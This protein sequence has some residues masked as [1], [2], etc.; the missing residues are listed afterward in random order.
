MTVKAVA[1]YIHSGHLNFKTAPYE[2]WVRIMNGNVNVNDNFNRGIAKAQYPWRLFH[3]L[4]FRWE[5]PT[6]WKNK[7]EARLRFV[8]PVSITFDTFPD[9]ARYE[10]I[11]FVWD[12][13][14]CYFEKMCR[15][16]DKHEVK[17]AIFTS[18]Q[19]ADRIRKRFP[20]MNIMYCPE[21][22]DTSN[23]HEGKPLKDRSIDVL[24]FGRNGN[25]NGITEL[26]NYGTTELR[27]YGDTD[28]RRDGNR[29]YDNENQ[30]EKGGRGIRYVCTKVDGKF[31][32]TNEQLYEAMGDA[33]ITIAL[34]RSVTQ[35]EIAGDIETL[36][37]RYWE[38]MLSRMVMVGHA[39]KELVD[40]IGYNPIIELD[41]DHVKEQIF[42]ILE[43][44]EDYQKLVDKNRETA[45]RLG[46]WT[47]RMKEVMS[48]LE[49]KD[50]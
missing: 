23:Y 4:A 8:E 48:F 40:L 2:A 29:R 19:T 47:L 12:C 42:E 44:I 18:S 11:P 49:S 5:L 28:I 10:I 31:I 37:Q 6:L 1:P 22:V 50:Y 16:L 24:E 20:K 38:N 15:W 41:R 21:A 33:K 26:R 25:V 14:P 9:Y 30:N 39:P 3:G 36:T 45:L 46:D 17:T 43:H 35:P 13:W 7:K 27:N 34:P 32:Y